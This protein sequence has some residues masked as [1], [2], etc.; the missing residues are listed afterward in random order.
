[1]DDIVTYDTTVC[2]FCNSKDIRGG[3][4]TPDI[5]MNCKAVYFFGV[6]HKNKVDEAE[7]LKEV[8]EE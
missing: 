7:L 1:M 4:W 3:S 6:W 5:C 8:M 2:P